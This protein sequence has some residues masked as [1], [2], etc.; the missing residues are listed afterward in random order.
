VLPAGSYVDSAI[1]LREVAEL[2]L[3]QSQVLVDP[4]ARVITSADIDWE[5]STDLVGRIG[6]TGSGTGAA[7]LG[8]IARGAGGLPR[9]VSA[10]ES[11]EI[12]PYVEDTAPALDEALKNSERIIIEGTQGFGLSPIHGDAWPNCTS[13]DTTAAAFIAEAGLSPRW[14]D[15][16]YLVIRCHPIRVGGNSGPLLGETT[17]ESVATE[18]GGQIDPELTSVTRKTRRIA[19]FDSE[20]V[21][22]AIRANSPTAVVLNHVDYIDRSVR[23]KQFLSARCIEFI[24]RVEQQTGMHISE[25]GT[26][27]NTFVPLS[28]RRLVA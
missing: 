25:V 10:A 5:R 19:R 17:W 6:S 8:R 27:P 24:D 1:L 3:K 12:A 23:E 13:R 18:A 22:R 4:R 26:G 20:V 15:Q 14:V 9:S 16:I 7:V 28:E 2:G 21:R 11:P